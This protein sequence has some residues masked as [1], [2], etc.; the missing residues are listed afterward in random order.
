MTYENGIETRRLTK[1]LKP[2]YISFIALILQ[3]ETPEN[4]K[5]ER[6][7]FASRPR[8]THAKKEQ[9]VENLAGAG[10]RNGY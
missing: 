5:N 7:N 8:G 4:R 1:S 9:G 3:E 10:N 2:K 6:R